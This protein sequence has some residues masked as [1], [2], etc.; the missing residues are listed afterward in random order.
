[1]AA[2]TDVP[3]SFVLLEER[4]EQADE[5]FLPEV[6]ACTEDTKL[7]GLA[8][9]WYRDRRPWA[10]RTLLAYV[11]DGCDRPRHRALVKA[12]LRLAESAGDDELMA[13]FLAA[14]DRMDRHELRTVRRY[15]W[16]TGQTRRLRERVKVAPDP[17][18]GMTREAW[19]LRRQAPKGRWYF[20]DPWFSRAT[21]QYLRRR[22]Y[23]WFRQLAA[24]D[25]ERYVAGVLRALPLYTDAHLSEPV[26]ILDAYGLTN[27]LYHGS[28]ALH[29]TSRRL[30][31]RAGRQLAELEPAPRNPD[32]WRGHAEALLRALIRCDSLFV[33][34]WIVRWL[35]REEA[36]ALRGI[37]G[38]RLR[39][40]LL[41]P[42]PDVQVFASTLLEEAE[43]LGTLPVRE[44]L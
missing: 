42:Y 31:V 33:R 6:L 15:D 16:V 25:P 24:R 1:M 11:D 7:K 27:L 12:L 8:T 39:P 21:R 28:D 35:E 30:R 36:D 23:R 10:R 32:A 5:R 2:P 14:F 20:S 26:N 38:R 17:Q 4:F 43:R 37:D 3:V 34:R 9:R 40:L 29:R 22:A 13:H 41:S 19:A 18:R 44:W